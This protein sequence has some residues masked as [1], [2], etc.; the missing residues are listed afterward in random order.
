MRKRPTRVGVDAPLWLRVYPQW[1][2]PPLGAELIVAR[3][4]GRD[5]PLFLLDELAEDAAV[6]CKGEAPTDL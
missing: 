2:R 4:G 5:S 3:L 1:K 6:C